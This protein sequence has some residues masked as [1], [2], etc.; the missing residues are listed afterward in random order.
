M[1]YS[2][3]TPV[4]QNQGK[5]HE[6]DLMEA[7]KGRSWVW[8][9]FLDWEMGTMNDFIRKKIIKQDLL[10]K[11]NLKIFWLDWHLK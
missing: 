7:T 2:E 11:Q 6:I 10:R 4:E 9:A 8:I 5:K 1:V 3:Y